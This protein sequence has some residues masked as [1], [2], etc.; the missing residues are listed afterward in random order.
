MDNKKLLRKPV[1]FKDRNFK[2]VG[3][4]EQIAQILTNAIIEKEIM[5]GDQLT[6]VELQKQF[7]TSR[8]PIRE[9]LRILEKKGLVEII[10]RKG[11]FVKTVA[12][13]NFEENVRVRA[14]LEGLAAREAYS[15]ITSDEL[16]DLMRCLRELKIAVSKKKSLKYTQN[17]FEFHDIFINASRNDVLI[18]LLGPL[19][20]LGK[21][22]GFSHRYFKEDLQ[23][24][25]EVHENIAKLIQS[26]D[27][28]P[29]EIE[30]IVR[31]HIEDALKKFVSYFENDTE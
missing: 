18:E 1:K 13:K 11:C 23:K 29:Q 4:V 16:G 17:H 12:R 15:K 30:N 20:M 26:R 2:P 27:V 21:W 6:E 25:L 31:S 22:Y 3:L 7:G 9:A 5:E 8:S 19:R 24:S 10:S 14:V 28:D